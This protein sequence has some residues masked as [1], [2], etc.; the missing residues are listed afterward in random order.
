MKKEEF[1]NL[2]GRQKNFTILKAGQFK[3]MVIYLLQELELKI[4][5]RIPLFRYN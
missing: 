3:F 1:Y 5:Y 2:K 4:E